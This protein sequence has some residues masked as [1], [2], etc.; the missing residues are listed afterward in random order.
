MLAASTTSSFHLLVAI[1][2]A[3]WMIPFCMYLIASGATGVRGAWRLVFL[4]EAL[5]YLIFG[6]N[7]TGIALDAVPYRLGVDT[8]VFGSI[9]L[10]IILDV[11]A[12]ESRSWAHW[13]GI[14]VLVGMRATSTTTYL[15]ITHF[16][17]NFS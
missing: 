12:R 13:L 11:I 10:A 17:H 15:W 8:C 9:I 1:Q 4:I 16:R 7:Q 2:H 5:S 3:Y 14:A 6:L